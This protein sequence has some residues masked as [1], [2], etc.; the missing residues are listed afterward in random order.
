MLSVYFWA[1]GQI[2]TDWFG[3]NYRFAINIHNIMLYFPVFNTGTKLDNVVWLMLQT[4]TLH[5]KY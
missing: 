3:I 4:L 2:Q 1:F 5:Q